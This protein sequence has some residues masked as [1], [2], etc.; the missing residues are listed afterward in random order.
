MAQIFVYKCNSMG[1]MLTFRKL[2]SDAQA[3][4][5]ICPNCAN[6]GV[7]YVTTTSDEEKNR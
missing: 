7:S 4:N 5:H 2:L 3:K 1:H 6:K